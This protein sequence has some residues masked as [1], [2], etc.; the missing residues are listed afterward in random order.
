M[1]SFVICSVDS[2]KFASASHSIAQSLDGAPHEIVGIHD[3]ISLCEG[4]ARGL[5]HAR[6]DTIVFC[7]DHIAVHA[8]GLAARLDRHFARYDIVGDAGTRRCVGMDWSEA[9]I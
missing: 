2:A 7:H 5:A 9:G 6:G 1:I 8:P 3:A 4:W